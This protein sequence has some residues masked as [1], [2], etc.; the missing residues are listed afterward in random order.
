MNTYMSA[1]E[2]CE[3]TGFQNTHMTRLLHCHLA[4]E[5]SYRS[6]TGKTSPYY[7]IVNKFEKM[8]DRG[9]FREILEGK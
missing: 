4:S 6:G 3:A 5:F 8:L 9:E 1:K 7:I 2:Y